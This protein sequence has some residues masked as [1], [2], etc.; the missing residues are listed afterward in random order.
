MLTILI[1]IV[2]ILY[3]AMII[4]VPVVRAVKVGES[5][6]AEIVVIILVWGFIYALFLR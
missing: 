2:G 3:T 5:F 6:A 1:M 4:L